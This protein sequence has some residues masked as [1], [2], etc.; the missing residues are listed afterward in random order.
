MTN[1]LITLTAIIL[2]NLISYHIGHHDGAIEVTEGRIVCVEVVGRYK[3]LWV[4]E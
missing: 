4:C 2:S 3:S 1:A